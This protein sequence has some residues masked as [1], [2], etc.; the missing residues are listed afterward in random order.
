V[1]VLPSLLFLEMK[2]LPHVTRL[3]PHLAHCRNLCVLSLDCNH[4]VAPPPDLAHLGTRNILAY[5]RCQLRGSTSYRHVKLVLVGEKGVGKTSLFNQFLKR[6]SRA[7]GGHAPSSPTMEVA[8]F[9]YPSRFMARRDRPRTTFHLIDFAGDAVY[10]CTHNCFL[11]YRSIYLC[12]WNTAE[13]KGSL[14]RLCPW[15]HSIQAS[16]PGS[17]VLLVA[18]HVDRRPGLTSETILKWEEEVLGKAVRLRNRTTARGPGFPPIMQS[19]VMD[20]LNHEDVEML[21]EDVYKISQQMRHPKTNVLILAEPY[22]RSYQELQA[23]VEVK[24]RNLC[25]ERRV[26]PVL[27]HEELID[28]VRSLTVANPNGLDQDEEEFNLACRFLNEAGSIVHYRSQQTGTSDLYFLDPQWLFRALATIIS[29]IG[30][31]KSA[32]VQGGEWPFYFQAVN[33]PLAMYR[34]FLGMMEHHN[35]IVKLDFTKDTYM[36]PALLPDDPPPGYPTYDLS[37]KLDDVVVQY[38][39]LNFLPPPLFPQ[40][41]A[42]V[43]LYIRQ[44]SAQLLSV[45]VEPEREEGL[46]WVGSVPGMPS[47]MVSQLSVASFNRRSQ[48]YHVDQLG[49]LSQEDLDLDLRGEGH[50]LHRLK[51]IWGLS[52]ASLASSSSRHK[53]LTEKLVAM[54]QPILQPQSS[55]GSSTLCETDSQSSHGDEFA[56]YLFWKKGLF[57]EFPCGTKFWLEA[58]STALAIVVRGAL[59]R[60]VKVLSFL[61]SSIDALVDECYSGTQVSSYSPCPTCLASFWATTSGGENLGDFSPRRGTDLS[62]AR[63][64]SSLEDHFTTPDGFP[65]N[66]IHGER[67]HGDCSHSDEDSANHEECS[68]SDDQRDLEDSTTLISMNEFSGKILYL[69]KKAPK[70]HSSLSFS[71]SKFSLQLLS[72]YSSPPPSPD[73]DNAHFSGVNQDDRPDVAFLDNRLTLFSLETTVQQSMMSSSIPCP[74]CDSRISLETIS[75]H[76]MLVDFKNSYRL[77]AKDI[78]FAEDEASTLGRGGFGK[79][80]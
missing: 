40:L 74:S 52:M 17:P 64:S 15:L 1:C 79:V 77:R 32:V 65:G 12:L 18:T 70:L 30:Q 45:S 43:L 23:L 50:D 5:L 75:P 9:D 59:L 7:G 63:V 61:S 54:V 72:P 24:V 60:R 48:S 29:T 67:T 26:P 39:E 2:G 44:I 55:H 4:L 68:T 13:G 35:L 42:R 49:Y 28:Y 73:H 78:H 41:V 27:R 57:C 22:P 6:N 51:K 34:S 11:T 3:T 66:E 20:C 19:V 76:V 71:G 46:G 31:R 58:C 80:S 10:R 21:L 47:S 14:Q 25:L 37:S 56:S 8:T 16:V 33:L 36:V 69:R 62:A 53:H 38:L